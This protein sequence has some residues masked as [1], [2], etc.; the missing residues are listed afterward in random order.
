MCL[1]HGPGN[2][3]EVSLFLPR[4]EYTPARQKI[5]LHQSKLYIL[6][7]ITEF[8]KV[9]QKIIKMFECIVNNELILTQY[10]AYKQNT[11]VDIL[12]LIVC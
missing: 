1:S 5:A 9:C 3:T 11:V 2:S 8:K 12:C 7:L 4:N 10:L 6:I